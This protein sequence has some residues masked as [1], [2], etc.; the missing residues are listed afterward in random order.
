MQQSVESKQCQGLL[1]V[2][3]TTC[4]LFCNTQNTVGVQTLAAWHTVTVQTVR[5]TVSSLHL[6]K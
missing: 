5:G 2:Q 6:A 3:V 1:E 4:P